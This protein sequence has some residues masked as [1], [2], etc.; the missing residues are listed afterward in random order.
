M[1]VVKK[2]YVNFDVK[3]FQQSFG[4]CK[5]LYESCKETLYNVSTLKRVVWSLIK[6]PVICCLIWLL[7]Y[8]GAI[9]NPF[10]VWRNTIA[11][12]SV[13]LVLADIKTE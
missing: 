13:V 5:L 2:F 9:S 12:T 10:Q 3:Q 1:K 8:E 11:G 4:T 6:S 7:S